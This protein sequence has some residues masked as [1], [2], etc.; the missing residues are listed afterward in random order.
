MTHAAPCFALL[1]VIAIVMTVA[2]MN[3]KR[4]ANEFAAALMTAPV[5]T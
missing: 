3:R 2:V 1:L 4:S 5:K